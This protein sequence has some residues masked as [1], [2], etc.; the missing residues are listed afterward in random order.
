MAN[1]QNVIR[2]QINEYYVNLKLKQRI[3]CSDEESKIYQKQAKE[4]I[5]L[6]D[7]VFLVH[8]VYENPSD[9]YFRVSQTD[10]SK[11]EIQEFLQLKQM[12]MIKT[13]RNCV[14][15]F[16]VLLATTFVVNAIMF[17]SSR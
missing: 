4:N 1:T 8:D 5:N 13:I 7:D 3:Y 2:K 10:L 16:T 6:P 17:W 15:L 14:I 12:A 9:K 11:D